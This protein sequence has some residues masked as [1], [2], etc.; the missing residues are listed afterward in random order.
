MRI[1]C[2]RNSAALL[3]L[4]A[5]LAIGCAD[6]EERPD[7]AADTTVTPDTQAAAM[8]ADT[9]DIMVA[10][11]GLETPESILYDEQADVYL[12]SNVNGPPTEKDDNG[13]IARIRPDGTVEDLRW[14]DG[15]SE[16]VTL[17]APKG[18]ALLG[19]TLFVSDIDS[20]R[21]FGRTSGEY[22]GPRG[23]PDASFLND[24]TVDAEGTLYV[25][26]TGVNADFSPAGTDAVYRFDGTEAVAVAEGADLGG[27]NGIVVRDGTLTVV[28]FGGPRVLQL[29]TD[30][31][32]VPQTLAELPGGQLDGI[33]SL[34]DGS[35]L[36]SSW[37]TQ[38]VYRVP[39]AG[40]EPTAL[41]EGIPSPADIG[42]DSSRRRV[43]IPVF[44]ENRLEFRGVRDR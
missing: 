19:D 28:G 22:F 44:Q 16:A 30:Q 4:P 6:V 11:V 13:F 9:G 8:P 43:L 10:D 3:A 25:S 18:L 29:S 7:A 12:V 23:V 1:E 15:A 31:A 27:P 32:S 39:G 33:V 40:G 38:T 34:P 21:A 24:L 20:V 35:F 17:H 42:W 36:V 14:I 5:L 37:E 2:W 26:D 41:L